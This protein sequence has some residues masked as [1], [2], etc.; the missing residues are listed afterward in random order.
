MDK[1]TAAVAIRK[2]ANQFKAMVEA[3]QV[4]EALGSLD[5]QMAEAQARI[6]AIKDREAGLVATVKARE[7][8]ILD[9]VRAA[10]EV[11]AQARDSVA[12]AE[13]GVL[14]AKNTATEIVQKATDEVGRI[15]ASANDQ[16]ASIVNQAQVEAQRRRSEIIQ[17]RERS[18][19]ELAT[20]KQELADI[21]VKLA[22]AREHVLKF[23][24]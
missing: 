5:Q 7:A 12:Q 20:A 18:V 19:T 2:L 23:L 8:E 9:A 1:F 6:D 17:L 16:A 3:A 14:Q 15:F 4:L 10:D 11:R 13:A 22:A 21:E 24:G